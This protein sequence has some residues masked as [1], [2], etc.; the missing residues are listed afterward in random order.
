MR[1]YRKKSDFASETG[2]I[3]RRWIFKT[4]VQP[5]LPPACSEQF[6]QGILEWNIELNWNILVIHFTAVQ[7][8]HFRE[9]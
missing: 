4:N 7:L 5:N 9:T 1:D 3:A 8:K 2:E 6:F